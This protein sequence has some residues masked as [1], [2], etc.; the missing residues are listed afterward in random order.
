MSAEAVYVTPG[1]FSL[2]TREA[3]ENVGG[4]DEGSLT[5]D[6]EIALHLQAKG[7]K[8][9][10]TWDATVLT[11]AP[12]TV[13]EWIKQRTRWLRGSLYNRIKH[14]YLLNFFKYGDFGFMAMTFDTILFIPI[15]LMIIAP[16]LRIIFRDHWMERVGLFTFMSSMDPLFVIG[17]AVSILSIIWLYHMWNTMKKYTPKYKIEWWIWPLYLMVYSVAWAYIWVF[18]LWKEITFQSKSWDTR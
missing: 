8:I 2:F 18:V 9:R 15:F 1:P 5:E 12:K 13:R 17:I 4:Y 7:Y 3:F 11:I 16:P 10:S 14:Y 6:H